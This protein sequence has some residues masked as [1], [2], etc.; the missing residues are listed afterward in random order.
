VSEPVVRIPLG[1]EAVEALRAAAADAEVQVIALE[2]AFDDAVPAELRELVRSA[3]QPVVAVVRGHAVGTGAAL[4]L[5][6]DLIAASSDAVIGPLGSPAWFADPR[7]T[8]ALGR[9]VGAGRAGRMLLTG[10][11]VRGDE[12]ERLGLADV[13]ATADRFSRTVDALLA[14]V[15]AQPSPRAVKAHL[16]GGDAEVPA[17]PASA[18]EEGRRLAWGERDATDGILVE[19]AGAAAKITLDRPQVLNAFD[20]AM[21]ARLAAVIRSLADDES[22]RA[23]L[24]TGSGRAFS[25][26]ADVGSSLGGDADIQSQLRSVANPMITTLRTMRVPVVAAVNGPAVGVGCSVALASDLVVASDSATLQLA[27]SNVGLSLDGGATASVIARGGFTRASRMAL[28]AAPV[29]ARDALAAGLIDEVVYPD[30]LQSTADA[31]VRRL[32][33]G[34][35]Q[36]YAATKRMLNQRAFEGLGDVLDREAVTFGQLMRTADFPE[37]V[38]SFLERRRP[39]FVGFG[40]GGQ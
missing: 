11:R 20:E 32:A 22:L 24:I 36:S 33:A 4:L 21:S 2:G 19:R 34:P 9:R 3:A 1:P 38:A 23:L 8:E 30:E 25:A 35:T 31:L 40:S 26:G 13:T 28:L 7:A 5:A 37:A 39:N 15:A 18:P 17:T 12:A 29:S 14:S 6:A 27:F 10:E 16:A